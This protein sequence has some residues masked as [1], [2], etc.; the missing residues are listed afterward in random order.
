MKLLTILLVFSSLLSAQQ[1][2]VLSGFIR[3]K[4]NKESLPYATVSIKALKIGTSTN[5]EGYYAIP[6]IPEGQYEVTVSVLGYQSSTF[7]INTSESKRIVHDAF[8]SD[9]AV[10]VSEVIIEAEKAEEKRS[11]QTGRISMQAKDI[12][13]LPTF[14]EADVFRALQMMPGVK[15]TSEISSGLNVRG[16]SSDQNLILLD[17]TV[18]Y[19]PSH[20][21]GLFSTFNN[22]AIKDIDLMKGG[23]P[24]EYGGRLSSVLNVTNIDGDRVKAHGKASISM[25]STRV[26]GEGPVGNGAWFLSGRRTYLDQLVKFAGLDT[27]KDALP[28]Y[29]FYD[30]NAKLT[31][32]FGENDKV[33]VVGYFGDDDLTYSLGDNE[34]SL[35]M[36]WGNRTAAM[37]WTHVFSQTL[38][39]DFTASY[40]H[41]TAKIGADFGGTDISQENSVYDYSLKADVDFFLSNEHLVKLG[42]WWSQYDIGYIQ[43]GDGDPYVFKERPAQISFYGQDEWSINERWRTQFGLRIEY[44]DLSKHISVGPRFNAR[45]NIDEYSSLKFASG[46]YYQFL[47]AVPAGSDNGFSPFDIWVPINEKMNPSKSIDFVLGYDTKY[48]EDFKISL[49][50]YYKLYREVLLFRREITQTLDV[51]KLFYTGSG[52]SYG[53][54]FFLQK[55][56]GDFTGMI[57]YTLAWTHRTFLELNDG[58][59]FMPKF[60]RRHD[61]TVSANYQIND[62]WKLGSV[63]TFATGQSYT[64]ASGVWFDNTTGNAQGRIE[65]GPLYS[66]RLLPYHRWDLSITKKID[67]FDIEGSWYIQIFNVYGLWHKNTWFKNF[68]YSK[69]PVEVTDVKLLPI[70]PSVGVEFKF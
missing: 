21:F 65:P 44:Q 47:N 30:A 1:K 15:A 43:R 3:D 45:Y 58:N 37:K 66:K 57:G 9:K 26:T 8:L 54:E 24:A 10:Q 63:F 34:L 64:P 41:Y 13:Q 48:F 5:I 59:E 51:S 61:L 32:D 31:Q 39:S 67:M 36:L 35:N 33:S 69:N 14:G 62:L 2:A 52:R 70:I 60:D 46:I 50:G 20:L 4:A 11:T 49:E 53:V 27:G 55:N 18:V 12:A 7:T 28:L 19:N 29:F 16:G 56:A 40:S 17:G 23:F 42:V 38:F 22:D 25:L 68:D 6:N